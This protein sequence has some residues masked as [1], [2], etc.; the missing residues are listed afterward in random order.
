MKHLLVI[1][2][3]LIITPLLASQR[4][5]AR[6]AGPQPETVER[7]ARESRDIASYKPGV[8]LDLVVTSEE[9][10]Q[11]LREFPRL[12]ITQTE[13]QLKQNLQPER[14]LP[15][16]RTY[17]EMLSELQT[18]AAQYP[19]LMQ[20]TSIGTGW[21]SVY[22]AQNLQQYAAYDHE[23]W[24]VKLSA[25]VGQTEDE[26]AFYFVGEHHAREPLSTEVCMGIINNLLANYGSDPAVTQILDSSEVWV[27][28]LLNPD[29][30][31]IVIDQTDVWWRKNIRDNN[32]NHTIDIGNYGSGNDGVDLNRNYAWYWGYTSAT[33]DMNSA[34][35]HGPAALSEPETIA[36]KNFILSKR[37]L[38]GI[39]YHTYGQYVLYPYGYV[40]GISAPDVVELSTLANEMAAMLPGTSGGTYDPGPSWGLYPVSGSLDD[41][42]YAQTGVFAYTIEMA[43]EFIPSASF[44]PVIV[45]QQV[46]G[47]KHLLQ[48][49]NGKMLTGHVTDALT[50]EPLS[51]RVLVDGIDDQAVIRQ[52]ILSDSLFGSYYYFLPEGNYDI[53]FVCPGYDY[54]PVTVMI[55]AGAPTVVDVPM[56]PVS[57]QNLHIQILD[58]YF[59]TLPDAVLSFDDLPLDSFVSD[60]N[61]NINVPDFYPGT[62]R[63]TV[64]KPGYETLR[65]RQH[66]DADSITLRITAQPVMADD[67][68]INLENWLTTGSWS[69]TNTEHFEGSYCLTDSPNGNY[70]NNGNSTCR[71]SAPLWLDGFDNINLQFQLKTNLAL[72][73]DNLIVEGS[74]NG[75][76]WTVL[77]FY[78]GSSD[79]SLQSYNLN[80]FADHYLHLR[81]RLFTTSYGSG[82]G[83]Y[84]DDV[85]IFANADVYTGLDDPVMIPGVTLNAQPNPFSASSRI[86]LKTS[87]VMQEGS[88][89]IYN[90]KGQK[91]RTIALGNLDMGIHTFE[92]NGLDDRGNL[93]GNGV[94]LIRVSSGSSHTATARV[95]MVK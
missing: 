41:W 28:P 62:Y 77:G 80:S 47:A 22:T 76:D 94:Y 93:L 12:E 44:V 17:N 59:Q 57:A 51:A 79:W 5:V 69:R 31:K 72:D 54:P 60:F 39:G 78:E 36:F 89:R 8:Y 83:V 2:L 68:E 73:G 43:E 86:S 65:T 48:R 25:N 58:D 66:I 13:N 40:D 33:D 38:A 81:F 92:W 90:I 23:L 6:I 1:V 84:I 56:N 18:L 15:G 14:N 53:R 75:S 74:T 95:V 71:L 87:D 42:A 4:M 29:G 82:N 24:A 45:Q 26:P 34:T 88:L 35:Y 27:I 20:L 10:S 16:Y 19:S 64:T 49:K 7:F 3:V 70:Q 9:Y 52:P 55:T 63:L 50:G 11:L 30:H 37:F 85:R 67:F 61:G 91:V 32:A 46:E 21:G